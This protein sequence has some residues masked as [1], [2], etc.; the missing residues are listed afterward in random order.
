MKTF[1]LKSSLL[2]IIIYMEKG[3]AFVFYVSKKIISLNHALLIL[4]D[5]PSNLISYFI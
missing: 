2:I 4:V 5:I 1:T 3:K